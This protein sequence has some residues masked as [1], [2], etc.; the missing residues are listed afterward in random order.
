MKV[1]ACYAA[2]SQ[3]RV[4]CWRFHRVQY[5]IEV[6]HQGLET[7]DFLRGLHNPLPLD[8]SGELLVVKPSYK[9]EAL[10]FA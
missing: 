6:Y 7:G 9:S 8:G 3:G 4:Q 2:G 1:K 10:A 5:F